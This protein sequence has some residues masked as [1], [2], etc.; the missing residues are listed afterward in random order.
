MKGKVGLVIGLGSGLRARLACRTRALRADQE[1][2][3]KVVEPR[4]RAAQVVKVK[5]SR[6]RR[7]AVP[8]ALWDGAV[9][10]TK[11]VT[12]RARPAR[13]W[14]RPSRRARLGGQSVQDQ[15]AAEKAE[16]DAEKSADASEDGRRRDGI[17]RPRRCA[18][19]RR[20]R[21]PRG[22]RD[23]ADDSLLTLL[24]EVPELVRNLVVAEVDAAKVV[25]VE[26]REGRTASVRDGS[27]PRCSSCSGRCRSSAPFGDRRPGD[28]WPVWLSA[29]VVVRRA[30]RRIALCSRCS[31]TRASA[32]VAARRTRYS[33]PGGHPDGPGG[34]R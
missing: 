34:R 14:M 5:T 12:Q 11:A 9:K 31:A 27:S 8:G 6:G 3:A 23:R 19:A 15:A 24:G 4:P 18:P 1:Q 2:V 29:L 16:R 33:G 13:S 26:D 17:G 32:G 10:V 28:V 20:W 30:A 25:G 7:E 22:F 21:G